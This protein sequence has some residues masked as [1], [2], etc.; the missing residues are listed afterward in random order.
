MYALIDC[1]N[2][3]ASCERVFNPSL[4][5]KP[6]VVLSNNDGCV[7]ARSN[8]AKKLGIPMGAPAYQYEAVFERQGVGVFSANFPL[9]GDMSRRV[10]SILS[11]YSPQQEI[12]SI[13][14]C[15][16]DFSGMSVDFR[17]Y[18]LK[19]KLHVEKWTGIPI[20]IGIAATKALAKAANRI[21]KKFPER[22]EGCHVIDTEEKRIKALKWIDVEDVW[23]IGR[24]NAAKLRA[25]GVRKACDFVNLS[26]SWVQKYMTVT[27]LSLQKELNGIPSIP[28]ELPEKRQSI[29]ITR[30]F[31]AD[32][33]DIEEIRERI[34]T[35]TSMC[36]EKL[37]LQQSLCRKMMVFLET[38]RFK[39]KEMQYNPSVL[40][41]LPFATDSTLELA[42][43]AVG[44]LKQ[45]YKEQFLYKRAGVILMDFEDADRYQPSLF[46]NSNPKHK[47]LMEKMDAIN[48]KYHKDVVHLGVQDFTRH[49]MR[50]EHLSRQYTTNIRDILVVEI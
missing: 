17:E 32:K 48:R 21:A 35:F 41:R 23:G 14:E 12:Y 10:M 8:E 38:N 29:A 43:F 18:G 42:K 24:R 22:T 50:Q 30:T 16:L 19:M 40:V 28:M 15:F 3:Y 45:I 27:G 1:N 4:I 39:G 34:A 26:P 46:L 20:S 31:D 13:D 37:R 6:V 49:K 2:F 47:L 9:Y 7:I 11:T 36:A 25:I 44:G 33:G 5:D